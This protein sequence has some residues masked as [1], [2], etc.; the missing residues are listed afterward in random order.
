MGVGPCCDDPQSDCPHLVVR[1]A[2]VD[3]EIAS[4]VGTTSYAPDVVVGLA[5][6][7][8]S[9]RCTVSAMVG[10][11]SAIGG[12]D[13]SNVPLVANVFCPSVDGNVD[14]ELHVGDI[15][16][17]SAASKPIAIDEIVW[18]HQ[19]SV[20]LKAM[21]TIESATGGAQTDDPL[22]TPDFERVVRIDFQAIVAVDSTD[23]HPSCPLQ[24]NVGGTLR[25]DARAADYSMRHDALC[26]GC[27]M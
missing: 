14:V 1:A 19:C 5:A 6:S 20:G 8:A 21:M 22:V 3:G 7:E 17:L 9:T 11:F 12:F 25:Y 4:P 10:D 18:R 26:A 16:K 24:I 13:R 2:L 23:G 15:R 27:G